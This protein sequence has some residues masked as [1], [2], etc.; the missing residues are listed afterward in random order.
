MSYQRI[1]R[2][3]EEVR[4]EV[5]AVIRE[6]QPRLK[7]LRRLNGMTQAELSRRSGVSIRAIQ[8]YEQGC[9]QIARAEAESIRNLARALGCP[10]AQLIDF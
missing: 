3:S 2:I 5:D 9:V 10:I 4:R 1:D 8:A 6:A 7:L